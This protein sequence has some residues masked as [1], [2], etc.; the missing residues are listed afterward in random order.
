MEDKMKY[1]IPIIILSLFLLGCKA[2]EEETSST[3]ELEGT[4]VTSCNTASWSN[5]EYVIQ[6]IT[7]TGSALVWLNQ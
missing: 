4:W 1:I 7:V 5:T 6:T 2:E 3:T